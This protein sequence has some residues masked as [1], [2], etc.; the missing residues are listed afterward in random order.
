[1]KSRYIVI[2]ITY[3]LFS[4][5]QSSA[6]GRSVGMAGAYTAASQG[7]EAVFFNP[8]NLGFSAG[9][10]KTLNLFSVAASVN[11]N[12]FRWDDYTK[13]NGEFLTDQDKEDILNSIP[14]DGFDMNLGADV[15]VLGFSWGNFALTFS[16][17]GSSDLLLPKE[18]IELL[19]FGNELSETLLIQDAD[20]EGCASWDVSFSYGRSIL[21][22]NDKELFCGGNVRVIR[23]IVYQKV[24]KT[25][26]KLVTLETGIN[27][28]GDFA[29]KCAEGGKGYALDLGLAMKYK[30]TWTFGLSFLNL[31]HRIRWGKN[32][33]EKGYQF[34][35]D[36]LLA[37]NFDAD[38]LVTELSYTRKIDPFVTNMPTLIR[39]GVAHQGKKLLWDLD[40]ET[41]FG[42][43]MGVSKKVRASWGAEYGLLPWLDIL[44]GVSIGG[45]EGI[46]FANGLGFDLGK[47]RLDLGMANHKGLWPTKSKGFTLAISSG[48]SW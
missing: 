34:R 8:A 5:N 45:E 41:G 12:S 19:F 37:E 11:N 29:V 10:E 26:G 20:G 24:E 6:S 38:S 35:V 2:L 21:K 30:R 36:S 31:L 39:L 25:Q 43:G 46:T 48:L 7:T 27:G 47:Y 28:D 14:S 4:N 9:S 42:D 23:G 44:G 1:M 18:P 33:E 13:Y 15:S 40:L 16:G 3:I 32:T 17:R 22:R